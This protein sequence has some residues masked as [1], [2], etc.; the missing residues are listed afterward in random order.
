M[1]ESS[2]FKELIVDEKKKSNWRESIFTVTIN[3]NK[4]FKGEY[5]YPMEEL[6]DKFISFLKEIYAEGN[7]K[8]LLLDLIKP[9]DL[10]KINARRAY[11]GEKA[12]YGFPLDSEMSERNDT[13]I[14]EIHANTQVESNL[15]KT[16]KLHAHTTITI[17][18]N[19]RIQI[20]TQLI[21]RVACKYLHKYLTKKNGEPGSIYVR[22]TGRSTSYN[23]ENYTTGGETI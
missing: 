7:L 4:S 10:K 20:D 15:I 18:H 23:M 17:L 13:Q 3:L 21:Q 22:A 12:I 16:A 19:S 6:K 9:D 14:Q 1:K 8:K 2:T 5:D 11:K